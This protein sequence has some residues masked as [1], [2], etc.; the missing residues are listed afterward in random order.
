MKRK[1][2]VFTAGVMALCLVAPMTVQAAGEAFSPSPVKAVIYMPDVT[3]EMS[4][5][6]FWTDLQGNTDVVL[7]DSA[8][9][10]SLNEKIVQTPGCNMFDLKNLKTT[11]NGVTFSEALKTEV[12]GVLK[13]YQASGY[14]TENGEPITDEFIT[15]VAENCENPDATEEQSVLYGIVT[16]RTTINV[17]PYDAGVYD[18]L[19]DLDFD[20][21]Y[22]S[23][24]GVNKPVIIRSVSRDKE[25]YRIVSETLTGW[26]KASDIAICKNRNEWLSAWDFPEKDTLVI[27]EDKIMTEESNDTPEVS[28]RV[29]YMGTRLQLVKKND[30]PSLVTNRSTY[31][32]H[33]VYMPVRKADGSYEKKIGLISENNKTSIGYLPLTTENIIDTAFEWL[34]NCYGWG[35]MLSSE[36]CSGYVGAVYS[37]FGLNLARNTSW[38]MEMPVKKYLFDPVSASDSEETIAK[39]LE[40]KKAVLDTLPAGSILFFSGHEMIYL[41]KVDGKYY[42]IS[43]V[44]SIMNEEGNRQRLRDICIH[45]LD[46]KRANGS[47]WLMQIKNMEVPYLD[48]ED[49]LFDIEKKDVP[50]EMLRLYNPNSGEHFYTASEEEKENLVAEGWNFEGIGWVAQKESDVPVYRLYNAN[51]GVHHYTANAGEKDGLIALGW[52]NEGIGWYSADSLNIPVYREFDANSGQHNYTT[53]ISEHEHLLSAGWR[54]EGIAFYGM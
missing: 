19:S 36:D 18:D 26:V 13:D 27:L 29:L 34:G 21:R 28:K 17:W 8:K 31:S 3:P 9:I 37:C 42:V 43:S 4:D 14:Y 35:G 5:K 51:E 16:N 15:Q 20:Y 39:N 33:V 53:D 41:G 2:M 6:D 11:L 7:S 23:S 12:E 25:W 30:I 32:N 45:T 1:L 24:I 22:D 50:V 38:Q 44:S 54:G 46:T 48:A 47:S 10:K 52:N 40:E 49:E